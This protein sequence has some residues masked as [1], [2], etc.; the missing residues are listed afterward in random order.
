MREVKTSER[1]PS[2]AGVYWVKT[3]KGEYM[4]AFF[5]HYACEHTWRE[6]VDIWFE[7]EN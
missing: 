1:L 6:H 2:F 7:S 5:K 3:K 4:E